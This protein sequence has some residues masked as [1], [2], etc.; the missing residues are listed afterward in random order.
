VFLDSVY[1]AGLQYFWPSNLAAFEKNLDKAAS[2]YSNSFYE[3]LLGRLE[4]PPSITFNWYHYITRCH[5]QFAVIEL[6]SSKSAMPSADEATI[7]QLRLKGALTLPSLPL[8]LQSLKIEHSI[9]YDTLSSNIHLMKNLTELS[10][11]SSHLKEVFSFYHQI[12]LLLLIPF[13]HFVD[14]AHSF[15]VRKAEVF[16][17]E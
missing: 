6:K 14:P 4:G 9:L 15:Q 16:V 1:D 3:P 12:P 17:L 7:T 11:D 13:S 5:L 10:L 8:S 2:L